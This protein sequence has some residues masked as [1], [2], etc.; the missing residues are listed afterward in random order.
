MLRYLVFT[1]LSEILTYLY[2]KKEIN[3]LIV[4]M[5]TLRIAKNHK[6]GYYRKY[7]I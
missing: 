5:A 1:F 4:T 2:E 3:D 7:I 6:M